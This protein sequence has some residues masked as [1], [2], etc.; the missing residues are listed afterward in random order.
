MHEFYK[1]DTKYWYIRTWTTLCVKVTR[2]TSVTQPPPPSLYFKILDPNS[3]EHR[4][5]AEKDFIE[6]KH[7]FLVYKL[8]TWKKENKLI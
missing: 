8:F 1:Q 3:M 6:N 5:E 7:H 4:K 2:Q